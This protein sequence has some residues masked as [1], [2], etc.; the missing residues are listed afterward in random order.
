MEE[1]G[2]GEGV[3]GSMIVW[4][5]FIA[6]IETCNTKQIIALKFTD[7]KDSECMALIVNYL[8]MIN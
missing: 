3:W 6:A 8:L 5:L 2:E 4:K 1:R 7:Q